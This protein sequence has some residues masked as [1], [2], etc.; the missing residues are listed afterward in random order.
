MESKAKGAACLEKCIFS[1]SLSLWMSEYHGNYIF[2]NK[3]WSLRSK[4]VNGST[5]Q[6]HRIYIFPMLN[7][8]FYTDT[9]FAASKSI[10]GNKCAQVF[11]IMVWVTIVSTLSRMSPMQQMH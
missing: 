11:L 7:T 1:S 10:K 6:D 4:Q 9:M 2:P 5:R 3:A 8:C